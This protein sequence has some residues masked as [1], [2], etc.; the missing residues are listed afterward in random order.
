MDTYAEQCRLEE[1]Q[2]QFSFDRLAANTTSAM[3]RS[4]FGE[5]RT[6]RVILNKLLKDYTEEIE[7]FLS[8][9]T[10]QTVA[11]RMIRDMDDVPAVAYLFIKAVLNLIPVRSTTEARNGRCYG[12][13]KVTHFMHSAV[14][15]I[16]DEL[17]LRHFA[18]NHS[19]I[20]RRIMKDCDVRGLT[21]PCRRAL[22]QKEFNAKQIEWQ[23]PGWTHINRTHLGKTLLAL[24]NRISGYLE[25]H[26]IS[27][28]KMK[29]EKFLFPSE[30]FQ[31]YVA[32]LMVSP[33]L[34]QPLYEPMVHPPRPWTN[35]A[36]LGSSYLTDNVRPYKVIK[37]AKIGYLRELENTDLSVPLR[38]LNAV[39]ETPWR[40]NKT[41][42]EAIRVAYEEDY[43]VAKFPS[44][45]ALP[46]PPLPPNMEKGSPEWKQN[47]ADCALVHRTNRKAISK[48]LAILQVIAVAEKFAKYERLYFPH[49]MDSRGRMYPKP[50]FLNP[51]GPSH[52]RALLEFAEGKP[53]ETRDHVEYLAIAGANAFGHD[54]LSL[55]DRIDWVFDNEEMFESIAAD[56][57]SDR[58]WVHADSPFEFLRFCLEWQALGEQGPGFMSHMPVNFDATCSGLQHFSALLKDDVGGFH[59][60]LTASDHRQDIY[61][62]VALATEKAIKED[63]RTSSVTNM[64][65]L[66]LSIGITRSLTKRPVMIV[67]YSGTFRACMNYVET[68]YLDLY[69]E[70]ATDFRGYTERD[71]STLLAPYVARFVWD[72]IS[73]TVIAAREAMDWIT[74]VSRMVCK[75]PKKDEPIYWVTPAGLTVRQFVHKKEVVNIF[76]YIDGKAKIQIRNETN[77]V[78]PRKTAQ[79]IS[80][81]YIHSMDAA[82]LQLTVCAA[83]DT[84]RDMSFSMIHDSFGVHAADMG[85]FV[86]ECIKPEFYR[87]YAH[88]NQLEVLRDALVPLVDT[89]LPEMPKSGNLVLEE[90]LQSEFFFS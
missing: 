59:V 13:A 16:H 33:D 89:E 32:T 23:H 30:A 7:N 86:N 60:N 37:R 45:N 47:M 75:G 14:D 34:V 2:R 31:E 55:Q 11:N 76:T 25:E 70:G 48:R 63:L 8:V 12:G 41:I 67:P 49:E 5:T 79:S 38:A 56:W 83:L 6:G 90:V 73:S 68:Y 39:Q 3:D 52:V 78:D 27:T 50:I 44:P 74:G 54:K 10:K 84:G 61:Q 1:E 57:R 69:A 42:L 35:D 18:K 17:T 88:T 71:I 51:Q 80:P 29:T 43:G 85:V 46:L 77:A 64:A 40:V 72:A 22:Y 36:L 66:A 28:G 87:M 53:I 19:H 21:R 62:A 20:M 65:N 15:M 24:F 81:N 58:R 4:R 26:N 82:H 9:T